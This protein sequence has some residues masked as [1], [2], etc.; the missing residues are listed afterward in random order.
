MLKP[1]A[2]VDLVKSGK[3][4][5]STTLCNG[6]GVR[7]AVYVLCM[8]LCSSLVDNSEYEILKVTHFYV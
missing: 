3:C 4:S 2:T 7:R 5:T 6:C 8:I 1:P